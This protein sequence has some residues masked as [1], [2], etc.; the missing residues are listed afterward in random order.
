LPTV[1]A[2][3]ALSVSLIVT[4][5]EAQQQRGGR[6][7]TPGAGAHG[8]HGTPKG[9]QFA[10]PKGDPGRGR[11]VFVKFECYVCHE[12]NGQGFPAPSEE[13]KVGPELAAMGPL[14]EA[15]YFAESI[16]NPGAVIEKGKGYGAPDGSSKMPS[17]NDSMTVQEAID[18]VA[19][20]KSLK[21]TAGTAP[22]HQG[23]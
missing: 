3:V 20:F 12:M 22:G 4:G 14:H 11:E 9:W 7:A 19:F 17:F 15:E 5:S 18:L 13:G 6:S 23:H 8:E 2:A 1:V 10:W 21:P 16:V